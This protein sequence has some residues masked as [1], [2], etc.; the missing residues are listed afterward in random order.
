MEMP[1]TTSTT[2]APAY[3]KPARRPV[4]GRCAAILAIAGLLSFPAQSETRSP[5]PEVTSRY[6]PI[7]TEAAER[8]AISPAWIG[9][10]IDVESHGDP[11]AVSPKGAIG[12]MQLMPKTYQALRLRYAL[13][14]DPYDPHDNIMAGA[15]YLR[16]MFDRF[17]TSGFLAAYNA[18]PERY[19][20]H[21]R[22]GRPLPLE[23]DAYVVQLT[24]R[25]PDVRSDSA[26]ADALKDTEWQNAALFAA[27]RK[28]DATDTAT[29]FVAS[30]AS[31]TDRSQAASV[32][33]LHPPRGTLFV[34]LS[35]KKGTP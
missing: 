27:H 21:L 30:P 3:L 16:E 33:R 34:S 26:S 13:G 6:T 5:T 14:A 7:I 29:V 18:G 4:A 23:T 11:R 19:R 9:A 35:S 31:R 22:T 10:V 15:A 24:L 2:P 28:R 32:D 8:F 20:D 25:L 1:R 17:G 12:L